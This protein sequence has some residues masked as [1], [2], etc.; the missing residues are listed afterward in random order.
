MAPSF[1][2]FWRLQAALAAMIYAIAPE[3]RHE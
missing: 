2:I 1:L 3:Q